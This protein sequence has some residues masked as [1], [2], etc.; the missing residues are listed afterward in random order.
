[1]TV[2]FTLYILA[3]SE[4][5]FQLSV[6]SGIL[7]ALNI[8]YLP[9]AIFVPITTCLT[10]PTSTPIAQ[11]PLWLIVEPSLPQHNNTSLLRSFSFLSE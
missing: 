5:W 6:P 7:T 8:S 3:K 2:L 1:M 11:G 9:L 4:I 10:L